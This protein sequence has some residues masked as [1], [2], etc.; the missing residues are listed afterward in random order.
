MKFAL[1]SLK[2][3]LLHS[4]T[5]LFPCSKLT[6]VAILISCVHDFSF[7]MEEPFEKGSLIG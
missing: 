6:L 2:L 3:E 7:A 4:L 1:V 5:V